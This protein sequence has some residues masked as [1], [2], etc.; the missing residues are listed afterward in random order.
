[1]Y[2]R[3]GHTITAEDHCNTYPGNDLYFRQREMSNL[4]IWFEPYSLT[5]GRLPDEESDRQRDDQV[6][7]GEMLVRR[8]RRHPLQ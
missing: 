3:Y 7:E 8:Q 6:A 2:D 5:P 1:M 4:S